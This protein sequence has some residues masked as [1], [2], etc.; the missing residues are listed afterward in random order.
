[1]VE[2]FKVVGRACTG[3]RGTCFA[4]QGMSIS[5]REYLI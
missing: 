4:G 1:V 5:P 2:R 3:T